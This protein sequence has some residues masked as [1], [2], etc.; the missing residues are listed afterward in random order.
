MGTPRGQQTPLQG[1]AA[2]KIHPLGHRSRQLGESG[3]R[4]SDRGEDVC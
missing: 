4:S 3:N 2:A 1:D